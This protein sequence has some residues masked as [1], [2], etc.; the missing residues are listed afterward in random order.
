MHTL[1]ITGYVQFLFNIV[2]YRCLLPLFFVIVKTNCDYQ[3]VASFI[4]EEA[5]QGLIYEALAVLKEWNPSWLP[6]NF[7][8]DVAQEDLNAVQQ[9]FPGQSMVYQ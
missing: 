5:R 1:L 2:S 7:L 3:V 9:A 4:V 6:A 8:T